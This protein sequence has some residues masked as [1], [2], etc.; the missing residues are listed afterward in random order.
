MRTPAARNILSRL[1]SRAEYCTA[2]QPT[3]AELFIACT[4]IAVLS[5]RIMRIP[6]NRLAGYYILSQSYSKKIY[7]EDLIK[8]KDYH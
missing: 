7:K 5:A 4:Y 3:N 8:K 6:F 1:K 2:S